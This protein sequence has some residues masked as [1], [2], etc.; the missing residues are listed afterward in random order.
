MINE[1]P[2]N[3]WK[4]ARSNKTLFNLYDWVYKLQE[5]G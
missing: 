1:L 4:L 3:D 2:E 5:L